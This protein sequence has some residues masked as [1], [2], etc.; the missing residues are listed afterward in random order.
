MND[1]SS[2]TYDSLHMGRSSIDLYSNDVGAPFEEIKSFAAYVG[3]SPTNISVGARRLGL[4]TALLTGLGEDPVGDFILHF[5]RKEGVETK[6]SP[7]KPGHR[8]SAVVLGIEPPDKFPLVYYRDNCADIELTIDDV[9]AAPVADSKVFQFAGT[10]LSKEP[11]RSATMFA[12][13]LARQAG[14]HVIFDID[15]RPDQWHD[16]RAFGVVVRSV[17][18]LVD[19]VIGTEDEINATMLTDP[20]QMRLTHSQVSDTRVEGDVERAIERMLAAGPKAVVEKIGAKG[21]RI[22]LASGETIDAPGYPVEIYN[23]LGA[24]DAFGAGFLYGYVNGWDWYKAARLGN[25]C[26]AIVVTKHGCANFMP[27]YEE[28]MA[29]VAERGGLD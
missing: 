17:L 19:V 2:R 11:S 9:L 25:A 6:F 1:A 5:L 12:A 26:G 24:G 14:T 21:A 10:N 20:A 15:F 3:G 7:R 22:H 8:T 13:E 16:P 18:P 4:K 27:T 28:V 23:I 29:F